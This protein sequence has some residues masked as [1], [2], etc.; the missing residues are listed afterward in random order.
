MKIAKVT[1]GEG[2]KYE[3]LVGV[4]DKGTRTEKLISAVMGANPEGVSA[5]VLKE[6]GIKELT[7]EQVEQRVQAA[8]EGLAA[9]YGIDV[10]GDGEVEVPRGECTN[11]EACAGH[12]ITGAKADIRKHFTN[13]FDSEGALVK[14]VRWATPDE[15]TDVGAPILG[16]AEGRTEIL[17][18]ENRGIPIQWVPKYES[19]QVV[20]SSL[21]LYKDIV[22]DSV[23]PDGAPSGFK[24]AKP[25]IHGSPL[26]NA[27][28]EPSVTAIIRQLLSTGEAPPKWSRAIGLQHPNIGQLR[29]R[30]FCTGWGTHPA[31]NYTG[32][33]VT[34]DPSTYPSWMAGDCVI[35]SCLSVATGQTVASM[36]GS[37]APRPLPTT[38]L[39]STPPGYRPTLCIMPGAEIACRGPVPL[40]P[41]VIGY[42]GQGSDVTQ[43][44]DILEGD[45][46]PPQCAHKRVDRKASEDEVREG[47]VLQRQ[48]LVY[49]HAWARGELGVFPAPTVERSP[50]TPSLLPREAWSVD[51]VGGSPTGRPTDAFG[52]VE[53]GLA[54]NLGEETRRRHISSAFVKEGMQGEGTWGDLIATA[55]GRPGEGKD[56]ACRLFELE[57]AINDLVKD[58][59]KYIKNER[60]REVWQQ[61]QRCLILNQ[62]GYRLQEKSPG[63]EIANILYPEV[64]GT[65]MTRVDQRVGLMYLKEGGGNSRAVNEVMNEMGNNETPR[66]P[67][68]TLLTLARAAHFSGEDSAAGNLLTK[69]QLACGRAGR[70]DLRDPVTAVAGLRHP[71]A[72][73]GGDGE[74]FDTG[75]VVDDIRGTLERLT[76]E[77]KDLAACYR[78]LSSAENRLADVLNKDQKAWAVNHIK[79]VMGERAKRGRPGE[80]ALRDA[81]DKMEKG[82]PVA[83]PRIMSLALQKLGEV[84]PPYVVQPGAVT[85]ALNLLETTRVKLSAVNVDELKE[86]RVAEER[87]PALKRIDDQLRDTHRGWRAMR[88]GATASEHAAAAAG[89]VVASLAGE[90][91]RAAAPADAAALAVAAPTAG[92]NVPKRQ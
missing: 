65:L 14:P 56:L 21:Y 27:D 81:L 87:G 54:Q 70:V 47:E 42:L 15:P 64:S 28:R 58:E 18:H 31:P 82:A 34:K 20:G 46:G 77:N 73:Q 51:T 44:Q 5:E 78:I 13:V 4:E 22:G 86:I 83:A 71:L 52:V 26:T 63:T 29:E 88:P 6:W 69:C 23:G 24:M 7:L 17:I 25:G 74:G 67:Q 79:Q 55:E 35:E 40:K 60:I 49:F 16:R 90:C 80:S 33:P 89:V 1:S 45:I 85:E 19:W 57:G 66:T 91:T 92:D 10:L 61:T 43:W 3:L 11:F 39:A 12:G 75:A 38:L 41:E 62:L 53:A 76:N 36:P 72:W 32:S 30:G 8:R 68:R 50:D 9:G 84:V 59:F 37:S 48:W 2:S